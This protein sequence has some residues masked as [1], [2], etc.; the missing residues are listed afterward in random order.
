MARSV[1]GE[2]SEMKG[3]AHRLVDDMVRRARELAPSVEVTGSVHRGHPVVSC[4]GRL[5]RLKFSSWAPPG[6]VPC[7]VYCLAQ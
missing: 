2:L 1:V 3:A 5:L 7:P 4:C 6:M